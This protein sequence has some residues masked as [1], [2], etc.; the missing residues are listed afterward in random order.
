VGTFDRRQRQ[1]RRQATL[2]QEAECAAARAEAAPGERQETGVKLTKPQRRALKILEGAAPMTAGDFALK[3][4]P[5]SPSWERHSQCGPKGSTTGAGITRQGGSFLNRLRG[6]GWV[7]LYFPGHRRV[8]M[9][10]ITMKGYTAL[11][12]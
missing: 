10:E 8:W 2:G 6:K 3:M 12:G 11:N 1:A 7:R 9:Y 4:W 5:D